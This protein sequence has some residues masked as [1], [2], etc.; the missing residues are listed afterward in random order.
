MSLSAYITNCCAV[1]D[2]L[3]FLSLELNPANKLSAKS[4]IFI[5]FKTQIFQ[6]VVF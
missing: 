4:N 1:D 5:L 3:S 2:I 6:V